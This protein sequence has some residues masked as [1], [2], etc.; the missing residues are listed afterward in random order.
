MPLPVNVAT[1]NSFTIWLAP[2]FATGIPLMCFTVTLVV[3]LLLKP[4]LSVTVNLKVNRVST[5]AA[6]AVKLAIA[7]LAPVKTT[8]GPTVCVQA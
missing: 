5:A 6:G 7:V 3:A 8:V 1:V 4:V 2:A